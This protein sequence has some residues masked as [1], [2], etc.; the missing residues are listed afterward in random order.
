MLDSCVK[1][2]SSQVRP[3]QWSL[4]I[5]SYDTQTGPLLISVSN[6]LELQIHFRAAQTVKRTPQTFMI[7]LKS[8]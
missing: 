4:A 1:L 8:V 7:N 6:C 2:K 3:G 5:A